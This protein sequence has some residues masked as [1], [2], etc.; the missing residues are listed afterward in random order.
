[1]EVPV[2]AVFQILDAPA[3][4][5]LDELLGIIPEVPPRLPNCQPQCGTRQT[6]HHTVPP[7]ISGVERRSFVQ[8]VEMSA[9]ANKQTEIEAFPSRMRSLN[10]PIDRRMECTTV[11]TYSAQ[12]FTATTELSKP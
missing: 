12:R 3:S 8:P 11:V 9:K 6:K 10:E 1:M 2:A 4:L 5:L 7:T